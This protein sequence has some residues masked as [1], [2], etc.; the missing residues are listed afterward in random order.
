MLRKILGFI[1]SHKITVIIVLAAL[2]TGAYFVNS[3]LNQQTSETSYETST[4]KKGNIQTVV[5]GSGQVGD[6]N[7]INIMPEVSGEI[8]KIYVTLGQEVKVGDAIAQIDATT[9]ENEID[10]AQLA[11]ESAQMSLD[12]LQ[13]PV[14]EYEITKAENAVTSAE[15]DLVKLKLTQKNDLATAKEAKKAAETKTQLKDA[16]RKIDQ[17]N[18]TQPMDITVAEAKIEEAKQALENTKK[19]ANKDDIRVQ[20]INVSDKQ[21]KLNDLISQ[22]SK[23]SITAPKDGT[24][25]II[26]Y[27]E[28]EKISGTGSATSSTALVVLISQTKNATIAVN[29]VDVPKISLGQ[30]VNLTFDALPDLNMQGTVTSIDLIG[31]ASQGVV[32]NNV[33][34]S[35][36][37]QDARIKNGM[38][39]NTDI[40]TASKENILIVASSA[41]KSQA[42]G[43][44][45]Q[46]LDNNKQIKNI[47]IITGI[48][49]DTNTEVSSGLSEGDKVITK[50]VTQ[51][52]STKNTNSSDREAAGTFI[53]SGGPPD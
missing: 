11:L 28:G 24:V 43:E 10:Q 14:D 17:L 50:T 49:D 33:T 12:K 13:E 31:T 32:S 51:A 19:G 46:I 37:T 9:L 18:I 15:N 20:E 6:A 23:Y 8:T 45:V 1:R 2:G 16:Q 40:I 34:I 5:S 7:Q 44:Y 25:A 48:S 27:T 39:V 4:V 29:E 47:K 26:N 38:T 53:M 42:D 22:R 41:I 21:S 30:K 35:F 36:D 52:S 3:Q